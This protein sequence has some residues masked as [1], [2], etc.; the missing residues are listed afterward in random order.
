MRG[1]K[2]VSRPFLAGSETAT[3]WG[4]VVRSWQRDLEIQHTIRAATVTVAQAD[5][6]R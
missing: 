4:R 6:R 1:S 3:L 2:I 5:T